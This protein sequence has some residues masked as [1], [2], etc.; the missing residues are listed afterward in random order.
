MDLLLIRHAKAEA[1]GHGTRDAD[2]ALV[3][4]G[5]EQARRVGA[6]LLDHHLRPGVVLTSPLR[7]A[8]ETAE[9]L[10]EAAGLGPP[11][12]RDWLGGGMNPRE[13][14]RQLASYEEVTTRVA[15]VGHEPDF[16]ELVEFILGAEGGTVRVKKASVIL[17]TVHPPR[18]GGILRFNLWPRFLPLPPA[19]PGSPGRE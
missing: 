4:E 14:L 1:R 10:C 13:A 9:D 5:H 19:R 6:F 11:E 2:R 8:L 3:A 12:L 16:S 15:L 18:P 7:R 17:L